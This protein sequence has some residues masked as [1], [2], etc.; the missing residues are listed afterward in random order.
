MTD[1]TELFLNGTREY[2]FN[3]LLGYRY[4]PDVAETGGIAV[5]TAVKAAWLSGS[6]Y[7][8]KASKYRHLLMARDIYQDFTGDN[9]N[10]LCEKYGKSVVQ[11]YTIIR[12]MRSEY[13]SRHQRDMF[14]DE[15]PD[16]SRIAEFVR[17]GLETL[18]QL[19]ALCEQ[20]LTEKAGVDRATAKLISEG[21]ADWAA[22]KHGGKF[23]YI[24][25]DTE[26]VSHELQADLFSVV[27][28]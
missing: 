24:K 11:I 5:V 18:S 21:L 2:V 1:V 6:V 22:R 23:I 10:E 3:S 26:R 28:S 7:I 17:L 8:T 15:E 27:K 20:S 9:H 14:N 25:V 4:S 19:M 13:I 16:D 12:R